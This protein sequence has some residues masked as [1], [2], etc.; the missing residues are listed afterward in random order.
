MKYNIGFVE[1]SLFSKGKDLCV[2][3][4]CI[5]AKTTEMHMPHGI[6][7]VYNCSHSEYYKRTC[8]GKCFDTLIDQHEKYNW[9]Y[10][11]EETWMDN[12]IRKTILERFK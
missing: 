3:R 10:G 2:F 6:I 7:Y 12:L 5:C 4:C 9:D 1:P 11:K 8:A